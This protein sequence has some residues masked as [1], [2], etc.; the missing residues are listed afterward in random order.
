[1]NETPRSFAFDFCHI[2]VLVRLIAFTTMFEAL[3]DRKLFSAVFDL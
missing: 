1:M 3:S 2:I